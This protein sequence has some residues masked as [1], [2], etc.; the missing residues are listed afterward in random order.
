MM[1]KPPDQ[2]GATLVEL[3]VSIVIVAIAAS[4]ILGVLAM[5]TSS[6]A[7]PMI[8]HQAAA[9]AEAYL[10]EI[11]LKPIVDP[12]G[13]DGEAARADFDDLDD[14]DGLSDAGARD[15]FGNLIAGLDA[16]NVS[17]AVTP[18]AALPAVPVADALRVEVTVS[19]ANDVNFTLSG[20]R[21]RF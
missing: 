6:S 13:A 12:N 2:N 18:S 3:L 1:H 19:H 8:R 20:Y 15:Q 7:D 4:T 16:Y 10:E 17:I 21:T 11:L 9:I 14:Y 5:T